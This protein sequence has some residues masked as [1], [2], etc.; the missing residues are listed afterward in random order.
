V[1]LTLGI[2]DFSLYGM[3]CYTMLDKFDESNQQREDAR[4]MV[5]RQIV[6]ADALSAGIVLPQNFRNRKVEVTIRTID[7]KSP[8]PKIRLSELDAMMD[9]SI[10]KS[11]CGIV[12]DTG[13]T[14]DEYRAERLSKYE[15]T[16]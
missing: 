3:V 16:D 6:N 7:E 2:Y 9:G 4:T 12:S 11:L 14:L 1:E 8:L 5:Y 10:A 13:M 15:C